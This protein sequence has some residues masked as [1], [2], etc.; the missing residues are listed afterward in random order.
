MK[1]AIV[2]MGLAFAVLAAQPVLAAEKPKDAP[3]KEAAAQPAAPNPAEF[4]KQLTQ[5]QQNMQLMHDQMAKISQTQDP[6]ERQKLMQEHWNTM[7]GSMDMMQGMWNS[8]GMGCC[9]MGGGMNG[10][11]MM[12]GNM[13]GSGG[14]CCAGGG[15]MGGGMNGGHMMGGNMMGDGHMMG[16]EGMHGYYNKLTPEQQKQRQYMSDQYMQMQQMMMD[17]MMQHQYWMNAPAPAG[18]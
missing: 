2:T 16:W 8:G 3:K 4:D 1:K 11:H 5:M 13:M 14:G 15:M 9:M 6:Q 12:G 10:G 17:N 7:R 18:K